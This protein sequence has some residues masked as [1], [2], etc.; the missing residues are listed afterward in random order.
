MSGKIINNEN[1]IRARIRQLLPVSRWM[2]IEP[3]IGSTYGVPDL[4]LVPD[5]KLVPA[6][7]KCGVMKEDGLHITIRPTQRQVIQNMRELG[8]QVCWILAVKGRSRCMLAPAATRHLSGVIKN[9]E[10]GWELSENI[11]EVF[12]GGKTKIVTKTLS[13]ILSE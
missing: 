4:L 8:V 10:H 12:N 1:D 6:E 11:L 5:G 7:L 3:A 9:G 2:R 13:T